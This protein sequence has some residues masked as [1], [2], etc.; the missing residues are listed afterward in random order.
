VI[1]RDIFSDDPPRG[2]YIVSPTG[3]TWSIRRVTGNGSVI[4]V[5]DG[6]RDWKSALITILSL[7]ERDKADAWETAGRGSFRLIKRYR[8]STS[9]G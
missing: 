2:D 7:A 9:D 5:S 8:S 3:L 6:E 1:R 4:G